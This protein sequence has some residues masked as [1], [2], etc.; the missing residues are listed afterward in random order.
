[1]VGAHARRVHSPV[2]PVYPSHMKEPR[3]PSAEIIRRC[4]EVDGAYTTARLG[5]LARIPGN[6]VGVATRRD[7]EAWAFASRRLPIPS[8]NRVIGLTDP[9][10]V[11]E[12]LF[13][14][15]YRGTPAGTARSTSATAWGTAP[16]RRWTR[17][18]AVT[19]STRRWCATGSRFR[20]MRGATWSAPR[21]PISR[22]ATATWCVRG[23][24]CCT[25]ASRGRACDSTA[26]V[27]RARLCCGARLAA[28]LA[29]LLLLHD[30]RR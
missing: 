1:M 23:C 30:G 10:I 12:L 27:R 9:A 6:P 20:W 21:P 8:F 28:L 4:R 25:A 19:G 14:G 3:P 29:L 11:P 2:R 24:R 13:L 7:G 5:V 15:R 18:T 17:R 26:L 16:T 22:P